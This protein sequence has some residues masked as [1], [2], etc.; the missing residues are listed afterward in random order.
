M[1][2][3]EA[4]TFL[5]TLASLPLTSVAWTTRTANCHLPLF[6][7]LT[8]QHQH[9]SSSLK[10]LHMGIFY[11]PPEELECGD[12]EE[13]EIDWDLMPG[14]DDE[15]TAAPE[16]IEV[17]PEQPGS[18]GAQAIPQMK[19][20]EDVQVRLEMNWQ[21]DECKTDEDACEDFCEEC[22]GSGKQACRFC[23]GTNVLAMNGEFR[24][25]IICTEGKEECASCR[26]TGFIAPWAS[27]MDGH[28][29]RKPH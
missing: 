25:C 20:V 27:T 17:T 7:V 24:K 22:A 12:E 1:C 15:E 28:L 8:S 14:G 11:G 16:N 5:I 26:G 4:T 18:M 13:C 9:R 21:I 10:P 29:A 6:P 2:R 19:Q 23:R 3:F